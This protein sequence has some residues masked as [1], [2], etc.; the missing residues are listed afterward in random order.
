VVY[1]YCVEILIKQ[2]FRQITFKLIKSKVKILELWKIKN[3]ARKSACKTIV[4]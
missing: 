1:E 3:N 2:L 4:A